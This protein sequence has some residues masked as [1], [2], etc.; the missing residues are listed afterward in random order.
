MLS[1]IL[2]LEKGIMPDVAK[3]IHQAATMHDVGKQKI[4][5]SILNKPG[6]LTSEEFEIVKTHTFIGA[7]M[8]KNLQGDF[9]IMVRACCEFHHEWYDG[10][11]YWG[12]RI[13]DLPQYI[14]YVAIADVF[15]ALV[16]KRAYKDAWPPIEA[17]EYIQ[18]K[19]GTQFNPELVS[20]F[21]SLIQNND[22]IPDAFIG[23][24]TP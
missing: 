10:C 7:D 15:T 12:R 6:K 8:L 2:A 3:Q 1:E 20:L 17:M 4:P 19:A 21:I 14:S 23:E 11:G 18:N 16:S 13:D 9:G 5:D 22:C 24:V